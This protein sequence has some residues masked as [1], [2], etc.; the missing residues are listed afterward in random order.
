M[1]RR[2]RFLLAWL[3]LLPMTLVYGAV[4]PRILV[5]QAEEG[6]AYAEAATVLRLE[7]QAA[8][9]VDVVTAN[10][11]SDIR[12][13]LPALVVTVGSAAF[14]RTM[15]W[16]AI[17]PAEWRRVPVLA[18]LL[19]RVA[20]EARLTQAAAG[21]RPVSAVLLDQPLGRQLALIRRALPNHQRVG[22]LV[23][24]QTRTLL[25]AL[26]KEA[27]ARDL[28]L[29]AGPPVNEASEIYAGL[30]EAL[31]AA[32]VLLIL[33]DPL[34]Y[35]AGSLHNILLASYRARVP[36]VAFS[37]AY[38]K[39]GALLA[40]YATPTQVARQTAETVR[41]WLAGRGLRPVQAPREFSVAVNPRVAASMGIYFDDA[42]VIAEDLRRMEPRR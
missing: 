21:S 23:G 5:V 26:E 8:A 29:F 30:R 12:P 33:P 31:T 11:L 6:G 16:L 37:A 42:E 40:L 22:L 2:L 39:A 27:R 15:L 4:P 1:Q 3:W 25:P 13:A 38:V 9:T 34:I 10:A 35:Q 32:D 24:P 14:E 7:L 28:R 18:T 36:V 19:P 17:Q 20:Y 41:H